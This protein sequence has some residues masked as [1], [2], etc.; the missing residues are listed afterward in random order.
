MQPYRKEDASSAVQDVDLVI[1][2]EGGASMDRFLNI[3]RPGGSLYLINPLGF[4][5]HNEAARRGITVSSTQV[6][7]SGKQ[8]EEAGRLLE[9]G[10]LRVVLDTTFPLSDAS[11][12]HQRASR[13]SIQGKIVL[14][15]I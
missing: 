5:G 13:G 14:T 2:A 15:V 1:D 6:R 9:N 12:A 11:A 7:V 3:I 8:L 4:T 10:V